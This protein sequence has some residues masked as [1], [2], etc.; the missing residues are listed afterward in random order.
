MTNMTM[1]MLLVAI[2]ALL[3]LAAQPVL[4]GNDRDQARL[5]GQ[6]DGVVPCDSIEKYTTEWFLSHT[7]KA[8]SSPLQSNAL[9]YS[10]GMSAAARA[11]A[12]QDGQVTIWDVWPCELYRAEAASSNALR[13]IH[14][15]D[16]QRQRFFEAMSR[17]FALKAEE[18][19][20]VMHAAADYAKPP[21]DGIWARVE[22][23][24]LVDRNG[25][26]HWI[27]KVRE[28]WVK[29]FEELSGRYE[30]QI[31]VF[32]ERFPGAARSSRLLDPARRRLGFGRLK[33][34]PR[35]AEDGNSEGFGACPS[36]KELR[37]FD[38]NVAW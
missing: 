8:H 36:E 15:S 24:V 32:W 17:A 18:G 21:T 12:R 27:A 11:K 28:G 33:V 19:A 10:A 34:E 1:F 29:A 3:L 37:F 5:I 6:P 9:F 25:R 38:R 26:V 23:P 30:D 7:K 2:V 16:T 13:C 31:K 4:I 22:L 35:S 20:M 14:S